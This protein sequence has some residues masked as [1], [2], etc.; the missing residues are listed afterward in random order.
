[1][2]LSPSIDIVIRGRKSRAYHRRLGIAGLLALIAALWG[3]WW[4]VIGCVL[5]GSIPAS[6]GLAHV[7]EWIMAGYRAD[8]ESA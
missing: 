1:M 3:G 7:V 5:A 6:F 4:F 2:T 8:R